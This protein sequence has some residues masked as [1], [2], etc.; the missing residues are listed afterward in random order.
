M[1]LKDVNYNQIKK[2]GLILEQKEVKLLTN[3]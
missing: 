3:I 1:K 2:S